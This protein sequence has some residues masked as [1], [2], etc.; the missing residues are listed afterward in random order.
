MKNSCSSISGLLEKYHDREVTERE[1][2]VVESHLS[3]CPACRDLV[4]GME[5]VGELL[6]VPIQEAAER[7]DFQ[8]VWYKVRREL[9]EKERLTWWE[10]LRAWLDGYSLLRKRVWVTAVATA[11]I[12]SL[13]MIPV[14]MREDTSHMQLSAVQYVESQDYSVMIFEGEKGDMTVIWLFEGSDTEAP[15]S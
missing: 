1:R 3:E 2:A 10:S 12:L 13:V 7:V 8:L 6:R 4:R 9:R 11:M 14:F 15:I 5:E